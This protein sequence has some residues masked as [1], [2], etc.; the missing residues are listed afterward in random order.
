MR[1]FKWQ[2]IFTDSDLDSFVQ[3]SADSAY[4]HISD[5]VSQ[6]YGFT[7]RICHGVM[8]L[9]PFSRHLGM[10]YPGEYFVILEASSKFRHPVYTNLVLLYELDE[11]FFNESLGI[12]K[13][14][15]S[16]RHDTLVLVDVSFTCKR[17]IREVS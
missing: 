3:L 11:T 14:S 8:T 4:F 6:D 15:G 1:N 13:L 7:R 5:S 2:H 12:S 10:E 17:L 9:M 16:I